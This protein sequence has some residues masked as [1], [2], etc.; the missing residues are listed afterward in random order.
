M[1]FLAS[2]FASDIDLGEKPEGELPDL[3][4]AP[5]ISCCLAREVITEG[6]QPERVR[7]CYE[8]ALERDATLEGKATLRFQISHEDGRVTEAEMRP[9]LEPEFDRCVVEVIE[10]WVFFEGEPICGGGGTSIVSY[11]LLFTARPTD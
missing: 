8:D 2:A 9:G 1:W 3:G 6:I 11:T 7:A 4:T 10:E 5:V